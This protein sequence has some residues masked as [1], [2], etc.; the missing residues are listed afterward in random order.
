MQR[1][2]EVLCVLL[3]LTNIVSNNYKKPTIF[4]DPS[5]WVNLDD[6][7]SSGIKI[8]YNKDDLSEWIENL[9]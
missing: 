5:K 2:I 7:A 1:L 6:P 3:S 9:K 8:I 4:Y